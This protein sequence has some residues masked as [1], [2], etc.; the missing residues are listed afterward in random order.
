MR[1]STVARHAYCCSPQSIIGLHPSH[2]V[3]SLSYSRPSRRAAQ[4][5]YIPATSEVRGQTKNIAASGSLN[6]ET[7]ARYSSSY[8]RGTHLQLLKICHLVESPDFCRESTSAE[9][10]I[11]PVSVM[12][13]L[14][15]CH[16][17]RSWPSWGLK[18]F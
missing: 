1:A 6:N 18:G 7:Q 10:K 4:L 11:Y 3:T 17:R 8:F 5:A 12:L 14:R 15:C 13:F 9:S 2:H 16:G